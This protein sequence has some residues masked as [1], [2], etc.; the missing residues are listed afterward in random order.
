MKRLYMIVAALLVATAPAH[1]F[2]IERGEKGATCR[3]ATARDAVQCAMV[4]ML[5]ETKIPPEQVD[6]LTV[7]AGEAKDL[8]EDLNIV[9]TIIDAERNAKA[10]H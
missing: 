3:A 1:A 5:A 9:Q 4:F 8:Q 7:A 10:P 6:R 2:D